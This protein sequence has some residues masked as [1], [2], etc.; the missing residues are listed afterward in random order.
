MAWE[1]NSRAEDCIHA[2]VTSGECICPL[3]L[4]KN[5]VQGT[6]GQMHLCAFI[7]KPSFSNNS[8]VSVVLGFSQ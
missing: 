2:N 3:E 7:F 8:I 1:Q 4:L 6:A 5:L